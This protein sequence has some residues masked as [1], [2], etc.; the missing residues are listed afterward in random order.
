[1]NT[2][3]IAIVPAAGSGSRMMSEIPKQYLTINGQSIIEITINKLLAVDDVVAVVVAVSEDDQWWKKTEVSKQ[4]NVYTV[5]GGLDRSISV[6]NALN[7]CLKNLLQKDEYAFALVHDAARPCVTPEKIYELL[8]KVNEFKSDEKNEAKAAQHWSVQGAILACPVSDTVKR[9]SQNKIIT[10]TED[11]TELWLAHT[12]QLF[13]LSYLY[14]AIDDC[15]TKDVYITDEA[16][17]VEAY[18][19]HVMVVSD[20]RDN[21]KITYAEDLE[22]A[23][24]I[25]QRQ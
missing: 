21:I 16:S 3:T 22:W 13:P 8:A 24:Q 10:G 18:G 11:R 5:T 6:K 17:A 2:K 1:M 15:H 19:G 7:F 14:E 25:L 20:R 23:E 12:P 4:E 9:A